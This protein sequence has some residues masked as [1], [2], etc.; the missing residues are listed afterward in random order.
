MCGIFGIEVSEPGDLWESQLLN[1]LR[2][3]RNYRGPDSLGIISRAGFSLG[4]VR[5]S[6]QDVQAPEASQPMLTKK[7]RVVCFAGEIYNYRKLVNGAKSEVAVLGELLDA[8]VD[9]RQMLDGDYAVVYFNPSQKTI[10]IY[11]DRFGSI[12]IYYQLRPVVAVSSEQRRLINPR[13]VPAF[14]R[15]VI[16]LSKRKAR[17]DRFRHYGLTGGAL[18]RSRD[19]SIGAVE[20][21]SDFR[22]GAYREAKRQLRTFSSLFVQAVVSRAVHA[23][24]GF[25]LALSGGLDSSAVAFALAK[26]GLFP[27]EAIHV[28][29]DPDS[30]ERHRAREV[31]H[32]LGFPFVEI[33]ATRERIAAARPLLRPYFDQKKEPTVLKWRT[34][35]RTWF[36]ARL[37]TTK[38]VLTGEGGDEMMEGYPPH[39]TRA[40]QPY[41]LLMK[42]LQA[43]E[44]LPHLNL[45]R[46]NHIGLAL[47]KEFRSPFLESTLSY[48]LMSQ[49]ALPGKRLLRLW[50]EEQGASPSLVRSDKWSSEEKTFDGILKGDSN[51]E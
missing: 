32:L 21:A 46:L 24:K 14:G 27:R 48:W 40:D 50:L 22:V 11:R 23:D 36:T 45:D 26:V 38:V 39:T 47:S 25:S 20:A 17:V 3:M 5:L 1:P 4:H 19:Q 35:M 6:I 28:F 16:D 33:E 44:T 13:R 31:A 18:I 51:H 7:E 2:E 12:P 43:V 42:Q 29:T 41:K 15:V 10:T 37:A 8:G 9:L 49:Q 34:A 30:P